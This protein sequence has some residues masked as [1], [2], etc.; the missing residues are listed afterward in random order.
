MEAII[1]VIKAWQLHPLA[2]HFTVVL[3]T[4]A[5]V[6]DL[7]A[8]LFSTRLWL[9]YMALTLMIAGVIAAAL[10]Y[11]TGILEAQR[12][13]EAVTGPAKD[14]LARH[15]L[16]GQYL[17]YAF[18]ALALWRIGLQAFNFLASSRTTFL[19]LAL[20]A[21][22]FLLWDAHLGSD[23]LYTYG[24]GTQ[25]MAAGM[26]PVATASETPGLPSTSATAPTPAMPAV[27]ET[28]VATPTPVASMPV[29]SP[30]PAAPS[31]SPVAS[32]TPSGAATGAS[33]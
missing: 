2:D 26:G 6:A 28:P 3:L 27:H 22:G 23:L 7:V 14:V 20:I 10:S 5:V 12:L 9:R 11:L 8:L 19:I 25:L 18:V 24:V 1:S 17:M 21:I 32:R 33:L 15:A 13:G 16:F 30:T 31:P 29:P 4:T